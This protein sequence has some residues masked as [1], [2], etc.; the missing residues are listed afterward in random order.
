[1]IAGC[2]YTFTVA[3]VGLA[4]HSRGELFVQVWFGHP[5]LAI[6][7]LRSEGIEFLVETFPLLFGY[8]DVGTRIDNP[9][10]VDILGLRQSV[11]EGN[12]LLLRWAL[13]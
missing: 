13:V 4:D 2:V 3:F 9:V 12:A 10:I 8:G 6:L 1:M 11:T 7:S 5:V